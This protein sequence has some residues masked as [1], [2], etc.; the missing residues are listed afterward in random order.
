MIFHY[1]PTSCSLASNIAL[2]E[3]GVA[4]EASLVK[5]WKPEDVAAYKGDDPGRTVPALRVGDTLI[6][7]NTAILQYVAR[8]RPEARLLPDDADRLV[9]LVRTHRLPPGPR[10]VPLHAGRDRP[11]PAEGKWAPGLP[12]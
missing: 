2:E 12:A 11:G 9:R 4:Y 5:L 10:A 7:E 3:A 6:T 1:T 8:L